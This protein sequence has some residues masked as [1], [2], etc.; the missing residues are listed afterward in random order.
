MINQAKRIIF[1]EEVTDI[2][3]NLIKEFGL[4]EMQKK[5][6][7]EIG[8]AKTFEEKREIAFKLPSIQIIKT[9]KEAVKNKLSTKE[10]GFLLEKRLGISK[11]KA[12]ELAERVQ[13]EIISLAQEI[14]LEI[15]EEK[16]I[17]K[18]KVEIS[19]PEEKITPEK[20]VTPKQD[21]YREP[22]E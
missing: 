21:I 19:R 4:E 2:L 17:F 11:E 22:I 6:E 8:N 5:I 10:I 12:E 1:P 7:K 18:E 16:E 3:F 13:K 9:A 15:S 20:P 14:S